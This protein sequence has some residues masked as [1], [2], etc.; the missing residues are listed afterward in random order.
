MDI[1]RR[2]ENHPRIA[3]VHYPGL[4]SH[5]D[6]KIAKAQMPGGYGGVISFEVSLKP[7]SRQQSWLHH[8]LF[9]FS[10]ILANVN[11]SRW[12]MTEYFTEYFTVDDDRVLAVIGSSWS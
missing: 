12:T 8:L 7:L 6:H 11:C 2:L 3:R 4:P 10:L 9:S 1:A 5:S